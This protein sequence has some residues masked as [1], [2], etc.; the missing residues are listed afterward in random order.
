[1]IE[2]QSNLVDGTNDATRFSYFGNVTFY[3]FNDTFN[4]P[5]DLGIDAINIQGYSELIN[6]NLFV[7]PSLSFVNP[8]SPPVYLIRAAVSLVSLC[9]YFS[10]L[11]LT[12]SSY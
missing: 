5:A 1:M 9:N 12:S 10:K 4:T 2:L 8:S 7:V 6:Q 3:N 11:K